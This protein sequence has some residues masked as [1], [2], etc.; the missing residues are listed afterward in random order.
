MHF[1]LRIQGPKK[2]YQVFVDHELGISFSYT[3]SE[4]CINKELREGSLKGHTRG[5]VK[6]DPDPPSPAPS[7]I[8]VNAEFSNL[9]ENLPVAELYS[10][11]DISEAMFTSSGQYNFLGLVLEIFAFI[12]FVY[13]EPS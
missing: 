8:C 6:G 13:T 9:D 2:R 1:S 4:V 11:K 7:L 10:F 12:C 5:W 3:S